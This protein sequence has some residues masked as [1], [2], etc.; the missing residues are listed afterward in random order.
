MVFLA[1][2]MGYPRFLLTFI[3]LRKVGL[4]SDFEEFDVFD[5]IAELLLLRLQL[6]RLTRLSRIL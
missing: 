5:D 1:N 6:R 3:N 4:S 2:D